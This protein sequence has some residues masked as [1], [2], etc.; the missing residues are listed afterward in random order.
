M[1]DIRKGVFLLKKFAV[2]PRVLK[3]K[4]TTAV[5]VATPFFCI[6]SEAKITDEYPKIPQTFAPKRLRSECRE[7]RA[8][9]LSPWSARGAFDVATN[10]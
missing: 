7:G 1:H 6:F 3:E 2:L 5:A 4:S 9:Q 10:N 8:T